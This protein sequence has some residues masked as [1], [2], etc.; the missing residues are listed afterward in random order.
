MIKRL[1]NTQLLQW[2]QEIEKAHR[3]AACA[4][5]HGR[6]GDIIL[7]NSQKSFQLGISKGIRLARNNL[8][9]ILH[10]GHGYSVW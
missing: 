6:C 1:T 10:G 4:Y 2:E 3:E 5:E 8:R 9:R 7:D